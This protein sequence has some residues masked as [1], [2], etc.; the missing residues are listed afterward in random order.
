MLASDKR[1]ASQ[2]VG[3][4]ALRRAGILESNIPNITPALASVLSS[5]LADPSLANQLRNG[6]DEVVPTLRTDEAMRE[7]G[8]AT[9]VA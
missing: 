9:K 2:P 5:S 8:P 7:V 6:L 1:L 4:R 3:L